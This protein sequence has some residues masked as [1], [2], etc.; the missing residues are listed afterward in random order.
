MSQTPLAFGRVMYVT[1][2]V[3]VKGQF[4]CLVLLV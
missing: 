3:E 2:N 1:E 4:D